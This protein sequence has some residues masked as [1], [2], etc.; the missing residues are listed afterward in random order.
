MSSRSTTRPR[1]GSLGN[2]SSTTSYSFGNSFPTSTSSGS[3]APPP[4]AIQRN[5][6]RNNTTNPTKPTNETN[7]MS[8]N[9]SLLLASDSVSSTSPAND[10][11]TEFMQKIDKMHRYPIGSVR[12]HCILLVFPITRTFFSFF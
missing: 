6:G 3:L 4:Q 5:N 7:L 1:P 9:D 10:P 11:H 8:F 2:A 12:V